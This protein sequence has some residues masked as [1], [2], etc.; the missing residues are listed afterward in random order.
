M[1]SRYKTRRAFARDMA[2]KAWHFFAYPMH[3]RGVPWHS[4]TTLSP[5]LA[6]QSMISTD[7]VIIAE[8]GLNMG[9]CNLQPSAVDRGGRRVP[10]SRCFSD[11]GGC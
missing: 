4:H 11:E 1:S 7:D 10:G 2:R 5:D 3:A 8:R 6:A 9:A